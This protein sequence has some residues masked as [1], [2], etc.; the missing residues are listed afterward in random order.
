MISDN[1][2]LVPQSRVDEYAEEHKFLLVVTDLDNSESTFTDPVIDGITE[3]KDSLD[4]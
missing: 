4:I 1:L 2:Y 3:I